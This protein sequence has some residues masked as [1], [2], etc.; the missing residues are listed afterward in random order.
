MIFEKRAMNGDTLEHIKLVIHYSTYLETKI[1]NVCMCAF[2]YL[3]QM[4]S[5]LII[6]NFSL[7]FPC[8]R[9]NNIIPVAVDAVAF[10][11]A[12]WGFDSC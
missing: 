12:I 10:T 3:V 5:I 11:T 7:S 6:C 4:S 2:V 1:K 9:S 8:H